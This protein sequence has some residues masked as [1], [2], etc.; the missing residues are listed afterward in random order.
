MLQDLAITGCKGCKRL[1]CESRR[2][3]LLLNLLLNPLLN[4]LLI[5]LLSYA[6]GVGGDGAVVWADGGYGKV[7]SSKVAEGIY[8][9]TT[10]PYGDVGFGGNA[11]AILTEEGVVLFDT[12][13]TPAGAQV[14]LEE[15]RKLTSQPVRY[16]INSHWHWDHW[17]GNQVV[18]KAFPGTGI[19][20]SDKNRDLMIHVAV[21]WNAPGL[22][23][24]LPGYISY[25]KKQLADAE[26][27]QA[28]EADLSK[29]KALLA[30]DQDFLEQKRSVTYTFPNFTFSESLTLLLGSRE[31]RILRARAITPGDTY[32]YLPKERVLI[33]GDILVNPVPFA[34]GGT[35]PQDWIATLEKLDALETE[36][37]IPGHG[38]AE[39]DKKYL[40]QNLKLFRHVL[41]DVKEAKANGMTLEQT[42]ES[43]A[44]NAEA[45]A[46]DLGLAERLLPSFKG[47]FLEVFTNR[48]YH[49]L[50]KPLD[51]SPT[52]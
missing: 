15:V 8:L 50:E 33:T 5:F 29:Q 49:E 41:A 24:D 43:L 51:D 2:T 10:T 52:S 45:Y 23:R 17:A 35:Y 34:V 3:H 27:K 21:P 32:V 16:V 39:H 22:E 20:S 30:A 13:G 36:V 26:A 44:K 28:T 25:L 1:G 40:E 37:I 31:I 12:G 4:F 18:Q 11:V 42:K 14:I 47:Y 9:F 6:L 19:I 7:T 46:A 48:A 38:E